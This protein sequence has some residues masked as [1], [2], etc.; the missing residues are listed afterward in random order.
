MN[1]YFLADDLSGALDAAA[2][3][4][5]AGRRVRIAWTFEAWDAAAPDEMVAFTTETRNAPPPEAARRVASV[6]AHGQRRGARLVYKK[7]D[8]TLRGAVAAE[9]A[10]V[11][12]AFPNA[13]ILFCPANPAV[14]R[15]VRDGVLRVHDVP[16]A[17]TEFGHD[18]VS[19]VRQSEIRLLLGEAAT[20]RVMIA[21][22]ESERDLATAVAQM[23]AVAGE[24]IGVGS[25][26]LVRP[27]AHV[28]ADSGRGE[29]AP[30]EGAPAG[31]ILFVCGSAHRAN[32]EQAARL[33]NERAV[34]HYTLKIGNPAEAVAS[35]R[36]SLQTRGAAI[37]AIEEAR[38]ESS[39]ALRAISGAA[40]ELIQETDVRRLFTTGGETMF[41]LGGALGIS[42]M[43]FLAE[44][45][46]GLALARGNARQGAMWL[47]VKP[48]GFGDVRTWCRAWAALTE[49]KSTG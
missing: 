22:A 10:A 6:I 20:S 7:I 36:S 33:A 13:R 3:F 35:T 40:A 15:T 2:A 46:P 12:H 18:P 49:G 9:L 11:G 30:L 23:Q 24:W 1:E 25:G 19:P 5:H 45:E 29:P 28:V 38:A 44:I 26:G 34:P 39:L 31:P 17:E 41:A 32:R 4:H 48:G 37:L 16:V 21:D 8:S 47:A 27:V 43:E 42:A 14:G